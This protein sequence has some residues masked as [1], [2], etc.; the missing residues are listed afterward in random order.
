MCE[1]YSAS[2]CA[3]WQATRATTAIPLLFKPMN[4]EIPKPGGTFVD[5]GIGGRNNPSELALLEAQRLWPKVKRFTLVSVGSG[6]Q[7]AVLVISNIK[8]RGE[9]SSF[10]SQVMARISRPRGAL[11]GHRALETLSDACATLKINSEPVHQR[12]LRLSRSRDRHKRFSYHRLNVEREM[13][14][15]G[16]AE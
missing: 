9:F 5:G 7:Q 8:A 11:A 10:I 14:A 13:E 3:I 1:G 6:R 12:M 16:L 2:K 4:I 15:I